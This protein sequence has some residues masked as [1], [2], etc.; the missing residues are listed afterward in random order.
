MDERATIA[1]LQRRLAVAEAALRETSHV[2]AALRQSEEMR[3]IA[4]VGGRMGMWRWNLRD[5][6]IWGDAAFL[7]LWGFPASDE[8]RRL[9]DFADRMSP[10]GRT[11]MRE[12]ITRAMAA[13]EEFDG[14]LA[15]VSGPTEGRWVRWRGRAEREQPWLVNGVSFDVT[16]QRLADEQL[17]RSEERYRAFVTASSDAV[18]RMSP[19]WL[20]MRQ[21]DGRGFLSDTGSPD[22]NWIETYILPED[23]PHVLAAI[24]ASIRNRRM[25]E[26][27]HRVRRADGSVGWTLSRAVPIFAEDGAITEWLGT[28][29]DV[30]KRK[31]AET[32]LREG[33]ERQAFLLKLSDALRQHEEPLEIQQESCRLLRQQ[34]GAMRVAWGE[35]LPDGLTCVAMGEDMAEGV[36][37]LAGRTWD[38]NEFDPSG[39]AA[40][41]RGETIYRD[42]VQSAEDLAPELKSTFAT[43]GFQAFINVPLVRQGRLETFLLAHWQSPRQFTPTEIA[44]MEE[45]AER[46][47]ASVQRAQVKVVLRQSEERQTFLLKL[48]DE[49]R[50]HTSAEGIGALATRMTAMHLKVDRCYIA[51]LPR[52]AGLGR[53]GSEYRAPGLPS[54][55]GEYRFDD[56]PEGM[57]RL[58]S[59]PLVIRDVFADVS[60]SE[61]DKRS[62]GTAM[63]IQGMLAAVLRKGEGNYFW[64]MTAATSSPRDWT[65]SD[66]KLLEDVAERAWGAMERARSDVALRESEGRFQQFAR[67]SEAGL[68]IRGADTL[69]M[70][71]VSPAVGSIYGVEPEA[72]LGDVERWAELIVPEDRDTAFLHLEKARRGEAVVHEFRIQRPSDGTLR[73]IRN[74]DFPLHDNGDIPRIGGIAE[75]VT[76]AKQTAQRLEVLVNEL[77]HRARNLL[78]VV[79][80]IADRTVKQGGSV[81]AFE[82]RL[83]ALSRA[84]GLLSQG[85]SDTVAVGALVH[86]ELAAHVNGSADRVRTSGLEVLLRARQVQ[87]F[88]L[89]LHELTTN[90]V[91]YGALK[92]D[93]GRLAITWELMLDRRG[94]QRLALSWIESGVDVQAESGT[95]RGYGTELIQEA[96][97]YA[98][99]ATVD[100][101]LGPDGVR[102]RI[103][104][105]VP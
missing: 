14:Q 33:E 58:E 63:S 72:L 71:F 102:C 44:W 84:Q 51:E 94:R 104:M 80:A 27:E 55:A 7:A 61:A 86:A 88:A 13:G 9:S 101:V 98:L 36:Y 20:Q 87:N 38:W 6:H 46:T 8:P 1:D 68:W 37:S 56:F 23:R 79:T 30:T 59:G 4:I 22:E 64:C 77:Q 70:E 67:A 41:K 93:T 57:M 25:F 81:T 43:Y 78:G 49:L 105:P 16:A 39:L 103:E 75:D 34:I 50:A 69:A 83:Q 17:R 62:I 35:M 21:L 92:S 52:G 100:Y 5:E 3:R 10:Q 24:D 54:L 42:D 90:A 74:T 91:K 85:G 47:A 26:L 53:I 99:D 89:A 65:G 73:W 19:N 12:M 15:I 60:L 32:M 18:Y 76:E 45:T 31:V 48:S 95:R 28:A 11:E 82:E 66:L 40:L 97:A 2:E 29:R 96:L